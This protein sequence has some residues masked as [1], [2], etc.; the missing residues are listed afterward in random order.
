MFFLLLHLY[1]A[2]AVV[3]SSCVMHQHWVWLMC[4]CFGSWGLADVPQ[5]KLRHAFDSADTAVNGE[6]RGIL[7]VNG[8]A[9]AL[10]ELGKT[11]EQV[12]VIR[13]VAVVHIS[14][15]AGA[16]LQF[17]F[18]PIGRIALG[19]VQGFVSDMAA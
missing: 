5:E 18:D 10:A 12:G 7:D 16:C 3:T 14:V 2:T 11:P 8:Q 1:R 9:K 13:A 17:H 6:Q 4:C 15:R 19:R